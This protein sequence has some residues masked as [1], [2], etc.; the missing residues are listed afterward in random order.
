MQV[1]RQEKSWTPNLKIKHDPMT[2]LVFFL[3][4]FGHF[5]NWCILIVK[6]LILLDHAR[7]QTAKVRAAHQSSRPRVQNVRRFGM[8]TVKLVHLRTY[9]A[10]TIHN[11]KSRIDRTLMNTHYFCV[12]SRLQPICLTS[13]CA[14]Q[15]FGLAAFLSCYNSCCRHIGRAENS[16]PNLE[17]RRLERTNRRPFPCSM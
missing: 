6:F 17:S 4:F 10:N 9:N 16:W 11:G 2:P 8:K 12:K 15:S 14:L 1:L 7:F 13:G 3:E 5:A